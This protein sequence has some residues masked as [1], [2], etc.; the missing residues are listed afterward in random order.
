VQARNL[1]FYI[2]R[3]CNIFF[4]CFFIFQIMRVPPLQYAFFL[5]YR[6]QRF[7]YLCRS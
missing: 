4:F 7:L 3:L 1:V 6:R 2:K 5:T